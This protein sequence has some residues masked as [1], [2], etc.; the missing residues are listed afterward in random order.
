MGT[1]LA[2]TMVAVSVLILRY[3]PPDE[4]P[5]PSSFQDSIDS[6]SLKYNST[7]EIDEDNPEDLSGPSDK[8]SNLVQLL[9]GK[10]EAS[11]GYPL[12]PKQLAEWNCKFKMFLT[13]ICLSMLFSYVILMYLDIQY[14]L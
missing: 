4:M 2:F 14:Q 10:G 12:I 5:L 6:L 1:L 7:K 8:D 13:Q 9:L 3:V 11:A